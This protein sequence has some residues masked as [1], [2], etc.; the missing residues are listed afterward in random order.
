MNNQL[1]EVLMQMARGAFWALVTVGVGWL[2][3]ALVE[4]VFRRRKSKE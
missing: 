1:G 4:M 2:L 3:L